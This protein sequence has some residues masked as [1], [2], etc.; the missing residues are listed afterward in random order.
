MRQNRI[1]IYF[2]CGATVAV[3]Q[4]MSG[5]PEL[6]ELHTTNRTKLFMINADRNWN[7]QK[8]SNTEEGR[9]EG[10]VPLRL[11]VGKL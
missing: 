6:D 5:V 8:I 11:F 1:T 10:G 9:A 3:V 7:I 4:L 2:A